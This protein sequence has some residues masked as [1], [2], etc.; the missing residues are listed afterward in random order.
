MPSVLLVITYLLGIRCGILLSVS[1]SQYASV[2]TCILVEPCCI[3]HIVTPHLDH[4]PCGAPCTCCTNTHPTPLH[5]T[6]FSSHLPVPSIL[7]GAY[8]D[9]TLLLVYLVIH[10]CICA[11]DPGQCCH[12]ALQVP[13][14]DYHTGPAG[15]HC[16][17]FYAPPA[18]LPA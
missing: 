8:T 6:M 10:I 11:A 2:P 1:M 4:W 18:T 7:V 9:D 16:P 15:A 12:S 5:R 13:P 14:T 3:Y 17:L